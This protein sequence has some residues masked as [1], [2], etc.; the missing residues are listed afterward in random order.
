MRKILILILLSTNVFS[1]VEFNKNE[2]LNHAEINQKFLDVY[3]QVNHPNYSFTAKVFNQGELIKK[4]DFN[5]EIDKFNTLGFSI[6]YITNDFIKSEDL[7]NLFS[8]LSNAVNELNNP[9]IIQNNIR[10][11]Y[12]GSLASSCNDYKNINNGRKKFTGNNAESGL[13]K[14]NING[15]H[16][17]V[18]C[19]MDFDN[20]GWTLMASGWI[21]AYD[22][23]INSD[24]KQLGQIRTY[25]GSGQVPLFTEMRAYC[26]RG[27]NYIVH[28]KRSAPSSQNLN[29]FNGNTYVQ[30]EAKL[31][32]NNLAVNTANWS[33]SG[34]SYIEMHHF[35]GSANRF[36]IR[37][38]QIHCGANYTSVGGENNNP[39]LGKEAYIYIR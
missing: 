14:I 26:T 3:Q 31:S 15:N 38:N 9:I 33:H 21:P 7:N 39:N 1:Q 18:Y 17:T 5:N 23:N 10:T 37:N 20:G 25:N 34:G 36:I 11:F 30:T 13:Y 28:L 35:L 8:N 22:S 4:E 2:S 19:D 12:D 24:I 27:A 6:P 16:K 29:V 32:G